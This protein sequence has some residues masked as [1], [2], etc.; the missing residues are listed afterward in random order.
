[1]QSSVPN[2]EETVTKLQIYINQD[3]SNFR[4]QSQIIKEAYSFSNDVLEEELFQVKRKY[5]YE[6]ITARMHS[7]QTRV[8]CIWGQK[9][10]DFIACTAGGRLAVE[11]D[12][13][14]EE[15]QDKS[16]Y[17]YG[18]GSSGDQT[19]NFA[20]KQIREK[21]IFLF[22]TYPPSSIDR[23]RGRNKNWYEFQGIFICKNW[24]IVEPKKGNRQGDKMIRLHLV[25]KQ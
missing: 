22:K 14:D 13:K 17:Y 12:F 19:W 21:N 3:I 9:Y 24:E 16:W 4:K 7:K 1:M 25:P 10:P 5:R 8:G 15:L 2:M 18:Q 20:N 6:E 11:Y 23:N